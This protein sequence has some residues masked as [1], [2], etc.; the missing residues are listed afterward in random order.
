MDPNEQYIKRLSRLKSKSAKQCEWCKSWYMTNDTRNDSGLC[1]KCISRGAKPTI[2]A[3][4]KNNAKHFLTDED[5]QKIANTRTV[6][7]G[8]FFKS[9]V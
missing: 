6:R 3:Y 8:P 2:E 1:P 5:R 9:N 4:K 7:I